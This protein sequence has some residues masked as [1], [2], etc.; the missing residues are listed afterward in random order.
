MASRIKLVDITKL[1]KSSGL[2]TQQAKAVLKQANKSI[3]EQHE[4]MTRVGMDRNKLRDFIN[5]SNWSS[6]HKHKARQ[7]LIRWNEELKNEI[8]HDVAV[9]RKELRLAARLLDAKKQSTQTTRRR[10]TGF[11]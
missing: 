5:G 9:K 2:V 1:K 8:S 11:V 4:F 3:D 7:E 10:R 6:K